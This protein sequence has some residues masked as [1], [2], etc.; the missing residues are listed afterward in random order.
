L[1]VTRELHPLD[2]GQVA[3]RRFLQPRQLLLEDT[4]LRG[5]IQAALLGEDLEPLDLLLQLRDVLLEI[6]N[7]AGTHKHSRHDDRTCTCACARTDT[8]AESAGR[9]PLR[10]ARAARGPGRAAPSAPRATRR[11][12]PRRANGS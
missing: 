5:H 8:Y 1:R 10:R 9:A 7:G 12:G 6:S 3:E 2:R 11:T 4:D